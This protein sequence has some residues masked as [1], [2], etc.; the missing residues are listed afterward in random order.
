MSTTA[1]SAVPTYRGF[2]NVTSALMT[3]P[4]MKKSKGFLSGVAQNYFKDTSRP[5]STRPNTLVYKLDNTGYVCFDTDDQ[6]S[7]EFVM[8]VLQK[9]NV[10][11][12]RNKSVSNAFTPTVEQSAH[13]FHYW[14]KCDK[15]YPKQIGTVNPA[16]PHLDFLPIEIVFEP[17]VEGM[18]QIE[19]APMLT[20]E[21][22]TEIRG[23][24]G[25][26]FE[27]FYEAIEELEEEAEEEEE[28]EAEEEKPSVEVSETDTEAKE[29]IDSHTTAKEATGYTTWRN[30]I[31]KIYNKYGKTP[32]GLRMAK[33]FSAKSK[34]K[35]VEADVAEFWGKIDP[36]KIAFCE[37]GLSEI[38]LKMQKEEMKK[39]L[40]E[41]IEQDKLEKKKAKEQAKLEK[42]KRGDEEKDQAKKENEKK[43]LENFDVEFEKMK[44][45][46][47]KENFKV[48]ENSCFVQETYDQDNKRKLV[49]RKK[50]DLALAFSHLH[51]K[52]ICWEKNKQVTKDIPFIPIWTECETIRRYDSM[53]CFPNM[54]ACPPNVFNL[55]T[56]FEMER[57]ND[58]PLVDT[59]EVRTGVALLR[60]HLAIMC[61][62]QADTLEEFEKW[63]AQMIQH[64]EIKSHMPIF[65]SG[66]GSGK[67]SFV[68]LMSKILGASK[69]R[70]TA[71]PEE[72]VWG[73]FNNMMETAFLVFFDE[74][75]KQMTGKDMEKIKNLITEPEITIQHKGVDGFP[76]RSFHR[77]GGLTNTWDGGMTIS[78]GS[79]RFLMC[80]MSDEKKG[81][82]DYWTAFY[83]L[84]ENVDVLRGFY[85]Y[86]K[87]MAVPHKLPPPKM[88]EFAQELQQ[89]SID[90]PTLWIRDLVAD[91]KV[92]KSTY[93]ANN[94]N[95]YK[96]VKIDGVD[97]YVIELFGKRSCELLMEWCKDNGY[98]K[99]E[100]TPIK[101]GVYLKLKKWKGLIKGR[102]TNTNETRY[103][104]S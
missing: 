94:K 86:Y 41:A 76:M 101:L 46:F 57:Y 67:G 53:D 65:Q 95:E 9:H 24:Q 12:N 80:K 52:Y 36:K 22:Y 8:S 44:V 34:K 37:F 23:G 19:N 62:H 40:F 29:F 58:T 38:Q 33:Y 2:L 74:I 89:L 39:A 82:M 72:Y 4:E 16:Y 99:Y 90:V 10:P 26:A 50:A 32:L 93:L 88:T 96:I 42:V 6:S 83:A 3:K 70:L 60:N 64:P 103:L 49:H 48:I 71:S 55:W 54:S 63:I 15:K 11:P 21:I 102:S 85:N 45:E 35:Y 25:I 68:Q 66:E 5:H 13:K 28:E 79:R 69:V 20:D 81:D 98:S 59:E 43:S 1:V 56:P 91:A 17:I 51:I 78:K 73:R 100:T 75:S 47:E 87:G 97:E 61:D 77:F 27:G 14:F 31:F 7:N 92:N 30:T 104:V 18:F 84:L